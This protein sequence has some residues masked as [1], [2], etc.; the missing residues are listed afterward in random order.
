[1]QSQDVSDAAQPSVSNRLLGDLN[2]WLA[3]VMPCVSTGFVFSPQSHHTD[4]QWSSGVMQNFNLLNKI[5]HRFSPVPYGYKTISNAS[6]CALGVHMRCWECCKEYLSRWRAQM[7]CD[8]WHTPSSLHVCPGWLEPSWCV[9]ALGILTYLLVSTLGHCD[10][11]MQIHLYTICTTSVLMKP[12]NTSPIK[13]P[14]GTGE[15]SHQVCEENEASSL[16]SDLSGNYLITPVFNLWCHFLCFLVPILKIA[17]CTLALWHPH[18]C[19]TSEPKFSSVCLNWTVLFRCL[20]VLS[21]LIQ[22]S[23]RERECVLAQNVQLMHSYSSEP[24][25]QQTSPYTERLLFLCAHMWV[26][27]IFL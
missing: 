2:P 24:N 11:E 9:W 27:V 5:Q 6:I 12:H 7:F 13:L 3:T 17:L 8:T 20:P 23:E 22:H 1:M 18:H 10:R 16:S 4:T 21:Q 25:T 14:T 15:N 19:S 26:C